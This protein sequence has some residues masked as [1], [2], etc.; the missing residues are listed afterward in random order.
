VTIDFHGDTLQAVQKDGKV[1]VALRPMC[2]ALGVGFS[3]QLQKLKN[4]SWAV[5][6]MIVTTGA[7]GKYYEQSCLALECIPKWLGDININ[8]VRPELAPKLERYQQECC[9]VLAR[10]FGV[11]QVAQ[12]HTT[13]LATQQVQAIVQQVQAGLVEIVKAALAE[14]DAN[15]Q[16][17]IKRTI[18]KEIQCLKGPIAT[19]ENGYCPQRVR[20]ELKSA[21]NAMAIHIAK[22][23]KWSTEK[24]NGHVQQ[25]FRE[26][27]GWGH[28][29]GNSIDRIPL[30]YMDKVETWIQTK[31]DEIGIKREDLELV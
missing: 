3:S 2:E 7:D 27:I 15:N 4:S 11:A 5:V 21:N 31:C 23:N 9:D 28:A 6:T 18:E 29:T 13:A 1:F 12:H 8:K 30:R 14:R 16:A 26:F 19:I 24:A 20:N 17:M 25:H 10:H 22:L